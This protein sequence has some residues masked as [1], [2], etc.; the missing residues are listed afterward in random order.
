[1]M[2]LLGL[3]PLFKSMLAQDI[4][5]YKFPYQYNHLHFDCLFF[6]DQQPFELVMGCKAEN[7]AIFL[8]VHHGFK[9]DPNLPTATY[10]KLLAALRL[11]GKSGERFKTSVFFQEFDAH[12]PNHAR[13][14]NKAQPQ[15]IAPYRSIT[16]E[17]HKIYF[18][19][20]RNNPSVKHVTPENLEK[21]L[22]LMG[23]REHEFSK[24]RNQSTCW[25][26]DKDAAIDLYI[27]AG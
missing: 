11:N 13:P 27:P 21:T 1:M 24:R 6:V 19:G 3:K 15:D 23:T 12:I 26:A 16:E 18:C 8:D 20:W 4:P 2:Q 22:K 5:R 9:I 10:F 25:T 17:A 14:E 7:F